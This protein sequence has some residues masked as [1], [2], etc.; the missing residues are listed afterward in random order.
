M[1]GERGGPSPLDVHLLLT[2]DADPVAGALVDDG[3]ET[4]SF[5]GYVELISVLERV[6]D[7][8]GRPSPDPTTR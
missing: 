2:P 5:E 8:H 4:T 7:R 3:G 1:T 6:L